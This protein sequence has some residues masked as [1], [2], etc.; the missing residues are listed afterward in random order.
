MK[1]RHSPFFIYHLLFVIC[2]LSSVICHLFAGGIATTFVNVSADDL[3]I[4]TT[5]NLT[6]S[7]GYPL[8][9]INKSS[10]LREI[11]IAVKVPQKEDVKEGYE[12]IPDLNWVYI[13]PEIYEL[14]ANQTGLSDV[15][16]IIPKDKK[17]RGRKF[18]VNLEVTGSSKKKKGGM[19][20]IPSLLTKLR[21]SVKEKK[22]GWFNWLIPWK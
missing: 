22:K 12:P 2:H 14:G 8:K 5:Y 9:V 10:D 20:I 3:L 13:T 6:V 16:L 19:T 15:I 1:F 18:Q 7:H 21:F 11:S 4:N 17:L